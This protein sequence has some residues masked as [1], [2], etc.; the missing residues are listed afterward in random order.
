MN[1]KDIAATLLLA[2]LGALP[3]GV[4]AAHAAYAGA[5]RI[6]VTPAAENGDAARPRPATTR[7]ET[8]ARALLYAAPI[9]GPAT[10]I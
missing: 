10:H 9:S 7:R 6:S 3:G 5:S 1:R 2:L 4:V 8:A